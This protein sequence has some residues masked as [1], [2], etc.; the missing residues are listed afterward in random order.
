MYVFAGNAVG[1]IYLMNAIIGKGFTAYGYDVLMMAINGEEWDESPF[2]PRITNCYFKVR[3]L[4][5]MAIKL[6]PM[7]MI[8]III[9][10]L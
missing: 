2:F 4:L 10:C 3:Q 7:R 8:L 5:I 6:S 1:Q 9:F